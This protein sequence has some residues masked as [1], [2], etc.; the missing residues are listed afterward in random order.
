[1]T[2][3]KLFN[4][5][6][7]YNLTNLIKVIVILIILFLLYRIFIETDKY[8]V[9]H[10]LNK[11][12]YEGFASTLNNGNLYGNVISLLEPSN[13]PVYSNNVCT[14]NLSDTFRIDTLIFL[15]N[16]GTPA[17]STSANSSFY[18]LVNN[19]IT[20]SFI[21][22]NGRTKNIN[23]EPFAGTKTSGSPQSF[24]PDNTYLLKLKN[25]TDENGLPIFTSQIMFTVN[26]NQNTIDTAVDTRG[27]K[28][29]KGFGIYGGN[30]NLPTSSEYTTICNNLNSSEL[31]SSST[32]TKN[33]PN[34][35][36]YI[37]TKN[38]GDSL[39]YSLKLTIT[40]DLSNNS[41]ISS[42]GDQ[43][44]STVS[45]F[46]INISY[47]NTIYSQNVFTINTPY[48]VRSDYNLVSDDRTYVY[49][50]LSEP[51][52]ANSITFNV[53]NAPVI[54]NSLKFLKLTISNVTI[55]NNTPS[56]SDIS[57]YK[58]TINLLQ[59]NASNSDNSNICPSINELVNTQTKTQEI[60]DNLEYQDK[61]KSEKLRLE[62]NKQ[63][64]LKL[65]DQQDQIDQLNSAIQ[66]LEDGRKTR[67]T[68]T[69]QL[70]VL[71][72]QK[73]KSDASKIRDLANQRLE[74]Q[75]N[76]Q[77]YMDVNINST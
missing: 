65:K 76:N 60:C 40:K 54:G 6:E 12:I 1:M 27:Y 69:D 71:Q 25:I 23:A 50:F 34:E 22:G 33:L 10:N 7:K 3:N 16:N 18:N 36:S 13:F 44:I 55:L 72:Y 5:F 11:Y 14:F 70:R 38:S 75:A 47:Q 66:T 15:L 42:I 58:Q 35:N 49:I 20:L 48:I 29:I 53:S 8:Q 21:D 9:P 56:A 37:F 68:T 24:N 4:L 28:Y 30:K 39:I 17:N 59:S 77:L 57:D 45:P 51:I 67:A 31:F 26:G 19:N 2:S 64:L 41:E 46:R 74:S 73:Q 32:K 61:V 52:I 63:Y 43:L 62:R